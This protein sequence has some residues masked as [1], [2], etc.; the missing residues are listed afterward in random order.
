MK[1]IWENKYFRLFAVLLLSI[2][3]LCGCGADDVAIIDTERTT[4][5]EDGSYTSPDD[6]AEY[7]HFYGHLPDNFITKNEARNLGW[8]SQVGNL[9]EVAPGMSIGGDT[10][11]NREGLLPKADGRKYYECDV[12]YEGGYRGE[13]RIV[14]SNDG[15]IFYTDDH[16]KSFEQLY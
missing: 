3:L 4:L 2:G 7:L 10:F 1:T 13:E 11:G 12:N 14:Y 6:V 9:D 5:A 8:D 15:L 16:Y